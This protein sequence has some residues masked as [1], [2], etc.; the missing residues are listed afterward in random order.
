MGR[1]LKQPSLTALEDVGGQVIP[2]SVD[3][4]PATV[5]LA[6]NNVL[7]PTQY[8]AG[9]GAEIFSA[10]CA[11]CHQSGGQGLPGAFPPLM[12][13]P[14]VNDDDAAHHI[15]VVLHGLRDVKV[16]GVAYA[17]AMPPFAGTLSNAQIAD[18]IDYERSSWG[19]RGKPTVA[20]QVAVERSHA[21]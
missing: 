8:N 3:R 5:Q 17:A 1:Q 11:A 21:P 15:Q 18:V 16:A 10:N 14:V 13:D 19:N 4:V 2:Q 7:V 20:E 6:A 9:K 12:G